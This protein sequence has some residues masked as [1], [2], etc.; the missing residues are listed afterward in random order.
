MPRINDSLDAIGGNKYFS[1]MDLNKYFSVM[2]L[3]SGYWQLDVHPDDPDKT[4]F[5][6]A[7]GLYYFKVMPY[8]LCNSGATLERLME[9]ILA[10]LHW[11][12]CLIYVDDIIC[13][14][15]TVEEHMRRL[16]EIFGRIRE[17]GLKLAPSKT[18]LFQQRVS[19]LG[20]I[21][22]A[23]GVCIDP[24]KIQAVK[25]WPIPRNIYELR[26][27]LGTASYYRKFC[28]SFCDIAGHYT[29]LQKNKMPLFRPLN[30][31][32]HSIK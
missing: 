6:T 22:S 1:V 13:F 20:H 16:D 30:V 12:T 28:K 21:V 15:K 27:F 3:S 2:D 14:S 19:F 26:S 10:G 5:F 4:A 18:S 32:S 7:D 25:E 17:M 24:A 29:N 9:L 8:G 23:L 11:S 31:I